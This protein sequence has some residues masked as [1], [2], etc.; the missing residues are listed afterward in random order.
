MHTQMRCMQVYMYVCVCV[1]KVV[2]NEH[3]IKA[4]QEQD[5]ATTKSDHAALVL[6]DLLEIRLRKQLQWAT[7]SQCGRGMRSLCCSAA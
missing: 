1:C 3:E 5:E 7:S 2:Y 4:R 6:F